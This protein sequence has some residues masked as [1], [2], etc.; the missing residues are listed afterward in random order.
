MPKREEPEE[1]KLAAGSKRAKVAQPANND[2]GS[3]EEKEDDDELLFDFT[4]Y[5]I[6]DEKIWV[7]NAVK[8]ISDVSKSSKTFSLSVFY[9][10]ELAG[11]YADSTVNLTRGCCDEDIKKA[12]VVGRSEDEKVEKSSN[13]TIVA[14]RFG[15]AGGGIP[16]SNFGDCETPKKAAEWLLREGSL[17][18]NDERLYLR[19][20]PWDIKEGEDWVEFSEDWND[21]EKV[22]LFQGS[23]FDNNKESHQQLEEIIQ[24]LWDVLAEQLSE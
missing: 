15:L 20:W 8:A 11:L 13:V 1:D 19:L 9:D 18:D 2:K 24:R 21:L 17:E 14:N 6:Q 7:E 4:K 3:V 10:D 5:Y 22:G 23:W 12:I 16:G